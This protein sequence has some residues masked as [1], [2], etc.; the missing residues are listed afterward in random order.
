ML[1]T[2]YQ[3][4]DPSPMATQQVKFFEERAQSPATFFERFCEE[5][6]WAPECKMYEV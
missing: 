6:P 5:M 1:S 3:E 2:E 4:I